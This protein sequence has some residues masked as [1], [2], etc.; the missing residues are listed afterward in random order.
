[1]YGSSVSGTA[2]TSVVRTSAEEA[3]DADSASHYGDVANRV[4]MT[5]SRFC[6]QW[7]DDSHRLY[8][9]D[10]HVDHR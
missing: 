6:E 10:W 9:K 2:N 5:L 3:P 4:Q 7:A 1:M 8:L